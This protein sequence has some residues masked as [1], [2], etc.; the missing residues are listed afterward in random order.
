MASENTGST[1]SPAG[2]APGPSSARHQ[3]R[4]GGR[5]TDRRTRRP[6]GAAEWRPS[7]GSGAR[8]SDGRTPAGGRLTDQD[9]PRGGPPVGQARGA[10]RRG[11]GAEGRQAQGRD[12]EEAVR[13]PDE[14]E[15]DESEER[16]EAPAGGAEEQPA[17]GEEADGRAR[18]P[19][20]AG[21]QAEG[22]GS[23]GFDGPGSVQGFS[24]TF[25]EAVDNGEIPKPDLVSWNEWQRWRATEGGREKGVRG[26]PEQLREADL[27]RAAMKEYYGD[28]WR[29][30]LRPGGAAPQEERV[31]AGQEVRR[32]FP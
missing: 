7:G 2:G 1:E 23:G 24:G 30:R 28:G 11:A 3:R 31:A 4:E 25:W 12:V 32:L 22:G 18:E 15:F 26:R 8:G 5:V 21:E 9:G 17:E 19:A 27:W 20:P 13:L 10:E 29:D 16:A 6:G 14:R